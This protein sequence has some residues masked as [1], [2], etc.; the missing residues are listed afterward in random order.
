MFRQS[1]QATPKG[2]RQQDVTS[3][4]DPATPCTSGASWVHT[5]RNPGPPSAGQAYTPEPWL[6]WSYASRNPS[7]ASG[8]GSALKD[9]K[10]RD[11]PVYPDEVRLR[12]FQTTL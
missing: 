10:K 4:P 7:A 1:P 9:D 11:S 5:P 3:T 8:G 2:G 12:H 6:T